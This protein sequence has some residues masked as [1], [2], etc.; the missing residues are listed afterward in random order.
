MELLTERHA[1]EI[2]LEFKL[3]HYPLTKTLDLN[4]ESAASAIPPLRHCD[5]KSILSRCLLQHGPPPRPS[6]S[7]HNIEPY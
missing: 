5:C 4:F 2:A 1:D 3:H 7:P 6:P